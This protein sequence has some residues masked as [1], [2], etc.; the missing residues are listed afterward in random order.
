MQIAPLRWRLLAGARLMAAPAQTPSACPWAP[1][2]PSGTSPMVALA[3]LR[4]PLPPAGGSV[5]E[6]VT[7]QGGDALKRVCLT[8]SQLWAGLC[9]LSPKAAGASR[10][11]PSRL[12]RRVLPRPQPICSPTAGTPGPSS[13]RVTGRVLRLSLGLPAVPRPHPL[14]ARPHLL[15]PSP[16]SGQ[17]GCVPEAGLCL[18]M[19]GLWGEGVY[20][21]GRKGSG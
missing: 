18:A 13:N 14:L 15:N 3:T 17:R 7:G 12:E 6:M 8:V 16:F 11:V 1:T 20:S 5:S 2:P 9:L 4:A 10:S 19:G 21:T